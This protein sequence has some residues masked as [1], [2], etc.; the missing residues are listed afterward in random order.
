MLRRS[1]ATYSRH[2][3]TIEN[4]SKLLFSI[5]VLKRPA[6][7]LSW[8]QSALWLLGGLVSTACAADDGDQEVKSMSVRCCRACD[9]G[10]RVADFVL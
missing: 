7:R 4:S 8:K 6:M 5:L 2:S 3:N 9:D 1:I 10:G